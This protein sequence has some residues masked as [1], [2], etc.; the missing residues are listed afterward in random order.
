MGRVSR[1]GLTALIAVAVLGCSG[2]GFARSAEAW[3]EVYESSPARYTFPTDAPPAIQAVARPKPISGTQRF[4]LRIS[5]GGDA[6]RIRFSNEA[7]F[8]PLSIDHATLALVDPVTGAAKGTFKTITFSGKGSIIVPQGVP[9]LSDAVPFKTKALDGLIISVYAKTAPGFVP[10]GGGRVEFATGDQTMTTKM[11]GA[12][13]NVTRPLVTGVEVSS[14]HALPVIVAF[15]DSLTDGLRRV[16]DEL[17]GYPEQLARRLAG[18]KGTPK[19]AVANA[20]IGGNRLISSAW[21]DSALARLDRDALR[22]GN[23]HYIILMEGINDIGSGG[24]G[25]MGSAPVV[26]A[27]DLIAGYRQ[28]IARAHVRGVKVIG[29]TLMPF[30]GAKYYSPAKEIVREAVNQWIRTSHEYDGVIDFEAAVRDPADPLVYRKTFDS[31]DH[32][33][34]NATGYAAMADAIDIG[35]FH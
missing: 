17:A 7:G 33:H 6:V 20:G 22:I 29:G 14:D 28:I 32:L 5:A 10:F 13:Y 3:T 30:K 4:F 8:D 19:Y 25:P 21:G 1:N 2:S 16:N 12:S 18:V 15:G 34:P 35:L 23:V 26:T 11:D 24:P 31:G 9:A 27:E